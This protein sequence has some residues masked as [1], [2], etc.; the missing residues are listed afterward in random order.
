MWIR[1]INA[2]AKV[3]GWPVQFFCF[4]TKIHYED[5]KIQGRR[6]KG[7]AIVVSNHTSVF[8]YAVYIFVFFTRTLRTVM[9][10]VLFQKQP[11]G[12]FLKMMG[13]IRVDR[14][15]NEYGFMGKCEK[16][17]QN[18]GLLCVFPEGRLPKKG[19]EKPL[20]FKPGAAYLALTT[21]VPVI[22]VYTNGSYFSK[23][24]AEVIIGTPI[25]PSELTDGNKSDKENTTVINDALREKLIYLEKTLEKRQECEKK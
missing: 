2:F 4:R 16:I 7:G 22:P 9:A 13:G 17:L 18:G 1:L 24:R 20:P 25:Y 11:L 14:D 21:G 23:K 12:T 10:E 8:D 6:I 3:T 15:A 19:E 5:K